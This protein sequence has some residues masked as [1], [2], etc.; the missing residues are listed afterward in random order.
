MDEELRAMDNLQTWKV[1]PLPEGKQA[2]DC[3]WV[4]RIK[5]KHKAYGTIDK[6]KALLV[7]KGFTQV[8]GID[9]TDTFSPVAKLT[10]FKVLLMLAAKYDWHLLQLD[11]NNAFLNGMLDEAVYVTPL[12]RPRRPTRTKKI[13]RGKPK[14]TR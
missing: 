2:I 10:S 1:V 3:K 11:V 14:S 12:A 9:F 5:H 4:Y 6:Y 7:A 8:E 13:I